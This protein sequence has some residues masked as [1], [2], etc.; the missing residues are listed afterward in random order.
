[1]RLHILR[2][3]K[4]EVMH[5]IHMHSLKSKIAD[6]D[7]VIIQII[8][9][10][11]VVREEIVLTTTRPREMIVLTMT[12]PDACRGSQ[13]TGHK[14]KVWQACR[15]IDAPVAVTQ[16]TSHCPCLGQAAKG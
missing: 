7:E 14:G 5:C 3:I 1:M 16:V 8:Q 4:A 15:L 9:P 2:G 6:V 13:V 12:R 10:C 11:V